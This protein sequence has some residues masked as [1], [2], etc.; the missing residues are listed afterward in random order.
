M[1]STYSPSL[2]LELIGN[3]DQSG[4]WGA[5]TNNNLGILL[6]Q[7]VTGVQTITMNNY[8]YI[9]TN[10]N[11]VSDE[12]RNA[13]LVV[14]GVNSAIR[15]VVIPTGQAKLYVVKNLTSGG[16]AI[17]FGAVTGSLVTVPNGTTAQV[18]YDGANCYSSLTTSAGPFTV[19]GTFTASSNASVGGTLT[20]TGTST[21]NGTAAFA[22][23]ATF[24]QTAAFSGVTTAPT[25]VSG[26]DNTQ[27]ATTAFVATAIT[28]KTSVATANAIANAG[29]WAV[30]PTGSKLYFSY[31]GTNVASLDSSGNFIALA[32]VTA[33]GTP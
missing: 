17:T 1:A 26:T 7:A 28:N 24:A 15:Q 8:D 18:Y 23:S 27:V 3:G 20:V 13:V 33:Y 22:N 29:G 10:Y 25:A 21:F 16:Y 4:T 11:G 6:E 19:S 5:T 9:L 2:K 32:N 30:T 12:A 31:N 14:S